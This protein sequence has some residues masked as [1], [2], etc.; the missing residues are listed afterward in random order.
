MGLE[1]G[2]KYIIK[3]QV[4]FYQ[5][6]L[7][8]QSHLI[9]D[10]RYEPNEK[11]IAKSHPVFQEYKVWEQINKLIVNTKIEAGTNRKGEKREPK[12]SR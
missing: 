5:R 12:C 10:C 7:K 2:L 3:N 11:A 6:E 4:V 1:K 8:D 9:S